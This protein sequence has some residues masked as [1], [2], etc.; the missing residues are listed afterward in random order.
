MLS[1]GL[2]ASSA[3]EH[4]EMRAAPGHAVDEAGR[5]DMTVDEIVLKALEGGP[6]TVDDIIWRLERVK[7]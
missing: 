1:R 2:F 7:A 3:A 5:R 4:S 6:V